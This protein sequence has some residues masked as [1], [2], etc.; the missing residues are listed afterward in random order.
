MVDP[1]FFFGYGHSGEEAVTVGSG[2]ILAMF[3]TAVESA[4]ADLV[5][6][7]DQVAQAFPASTVRL[8]FTSQTLRRLWRQRATDQ[9]YR[10]A[11]SGIEPTVY[12]MPSPLLAMTEL[13]DQ[14]CRNVVV[15]ALH[16]APTEEYQDLKSQVQALAGIEAVK[17]TNRPY[18]TL[19]LGRP[20]LGGWSAAFPYRDDVSRFAQALAEDVVLARQQ[21]AAL[22]YMAHGSR[23]FP[24]AGLYFELIARLR[25]LHPDVPCHI[26]TIEGFPGLDLVLSE[27]KRGTVRRVLL[28][29]LLLTAGA[30]V[31]QDMTG[32]EPGSWQN[33]LQDAGYEVLPV[34]QGLAGQ[35]GCRRVFLE[36]IYDAARLAGLQ[37]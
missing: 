31:Q 36:H 12:T 5:G 23:S 24:A 6:L 16:L 19:V 30:H 21:Q 18:Q 33:R 28:K 27:L 9:A 22:V 10:R 26:G 32:P 14:G 7:R 4:L 3:G 11:H 15:Q 35:E 17:P 34:L 2:I 37:L 1:G 20:A 13:Q 25:A 29:P 8:A